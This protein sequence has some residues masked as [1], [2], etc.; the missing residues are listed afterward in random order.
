MKLIQIVAKALC[1]I[2]LN[3]SFEKPLKVFSNERVR[4]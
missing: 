4:N 1:V 2:G 3:K